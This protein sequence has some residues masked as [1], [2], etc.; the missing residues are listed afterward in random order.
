MEKVIVLFNYKG[1]EILIK[2]ISKKYQLG[3]RNPNGLD[4]W[5]E[6]GV[7]NSLQLAKTS[8]REYARIVIDKMLI[9]RKKEAQKTYE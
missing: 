9:A 2:K 1:K 4:I 5:L 7:Y 3:I 6:K 8:G